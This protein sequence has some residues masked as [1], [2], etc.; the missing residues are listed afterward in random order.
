[1]PRRGARLHRLVIGLSREEKAWIAAQAA[2]QG[3]SMNAYVR[4]LITAAM[5][6]SIN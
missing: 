3:V 6:R 5:L 2:A 1:M 4:Q